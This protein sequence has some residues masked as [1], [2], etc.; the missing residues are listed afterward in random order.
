MPVE[1][2]PSVKALDMALTQSAA[3]PVLRLEPIDSTPKAP[4]GR[5]PL[6]AFVADASTEA[7][8]TD[9]AAHLAISHF[10]VLRGGIDRAIQYLEAERSPS[11]LVVDISDVDLAVSKV[12]ELAE[13]CE[14]SVT[15]VAV[16]NNNDIGLYRDLIQAGMT[17]YIVK[18]VTPQL[19]AKALVEVPDRGKPAAISEKLGKLVACIGARG[20]VGATTVAVGLAWHLANRQSRRVALVDLDLQH[21]SCALALNM[22][23]TSGWREALTNPL[24]VDAVFLDRVVA[25]QS[26]R[27]AVLSAEEPLQDD[28]QITEDAVQTVISVL[29]A[30]VHYLI[31]DVPRIA[32][33]PYRRVLEMADFRVIVADQTLQSVRDAARLRAALPEDPARHRNLLVINRGGEAGRYAVTAKEMQNVLEMRPS[34]I[35]PYEP[36]AFAKAINA[37]QPPVS[38]RGRSAAAMAKLASEI[39]GREDKRRRW[40]SSRA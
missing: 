38:R 23:T 15:V 2:A 11:I 18:P 3:N 37:G 6:L 30:Q 10:R 12:H 33:A 5:V 28:L 25:K 36:I 40:W 7:A 17:E 22:Q 27:L 26:E 21:G 8:V 29:R 16:G 4:A 1:V 20:G 35:F 34:V 31:V 39:S 14:P 19:L 9:C 32:G 24:R 13:V